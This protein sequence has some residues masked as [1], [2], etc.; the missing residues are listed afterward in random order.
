M[1]E[2]AD[3]PD[4]RVALI[5]AGGDPPP[6]GLA[7][8]LPTDAFVV[9]ADSGL[10]HARVLARTA[11]LVVGDLDSVSPAVLAEAVAAGTEVERHDPEKDA[12]DLELALEAVMGR[13]VTTVTIVGGHGGRLD[14]LLSN[15]AVMAAERFAPMHVDG[16]LGIAHV[17]IVRDHLELSG[18]IGE[19]CS[20]I[21]MHGT[22]TGVTVTGMRYELHDGPLHAGSTR[23][24]SNELVA[25]VATVTVSG[26]TVVVVQPEALTEAPSG[27]SP[28]VG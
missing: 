19:L 23:G 18:R 4:S 9:A 13:G 12:T 3:R 25:P 6:Y 5:F 21:P 26:G 1:P 20:L 10:E 14:H 16:W 17:A 24:T 22:A 15:I 11:D 7:A 27:Q 2:P 28:G 8:R